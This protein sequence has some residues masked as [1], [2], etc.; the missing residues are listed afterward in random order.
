MTTRDTILDAA[1][2]GAALYG[3][4]KLSMSD[5]ASLAGISRPT[6]YKHFSSKDDLVAAAVQREA[7]RLVGTV[8]EAA[9]EQADPAAALEAAVVM[10]LRQ[11]RE[12]PLLDRII[13]SEPETLL[14][15]LTT[16]RIGGDG[17]GGG[18]AV[19]LFVRTAAEA[20]V[21]EHLGDSLDELLIRR[22]ADMVARLL[23]SY[24]ISA[25]D[26]PPEVVA[27]TI[28]T[29]LL[30]GALNAGTAESLATG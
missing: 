24:A 13:G 7:V 27:S 21:R 6:L 15:Y 19:L 14:P 12:H 30:G 23:V 11:T 22:L 4:A 5:I 9:Q 16:D 10:A 3:L 17:G 2:E 25:P 20:L 8:L 26:D 1:V 18:A 28:V 29:I